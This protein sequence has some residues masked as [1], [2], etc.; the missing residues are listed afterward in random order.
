MYAECHRHAAR[1]P[2]VHRRRL[3]GRGRVGAMGSGVFRAVPDVET[4]VVDEVQYIPVPAGADETTTEDHQRLG[5]PITRQQEVDR[6]AAWVDE[7]G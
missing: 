4:A 1:Q 5:P 7:M 6:P 3:V 2:C